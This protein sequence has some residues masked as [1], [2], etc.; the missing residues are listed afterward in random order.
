MP[1]PPPSRFPITA[2]LSRPSIEAPNPYC[3]RRLRELAREC[4][5][6]CVASVGGVFWC[7]R[8]GKQG[9][10]GMPRGCFQ[11]SRSPPPPLR[12]LQRADAGGN[13]SAPSSPRKVATDQDS[14]SAASAEQTLSPQT[15]SCLV[16]SINLVHCGNEFP[17]NPDWGLAPERPENWS[18]ALSGTGTTGPIPRR[19]SI[20]KISPPR[21]APIVHLCQKLLPVDS[22]TTMSVHDRRPPPARPLHHP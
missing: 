17:A 15:L 4:P 6:G 18:T 11:D 3:Y 1:S 12:R 14:C 22:E 7:G 20:S 16:L 8:G 2:S 21:S 19:D 10:R 9:P 13:A 5:C